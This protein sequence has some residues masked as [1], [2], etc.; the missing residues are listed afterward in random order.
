MLSTKKFT[1]V[2]ND[3]IKPQWS[4]ILRTLGKLKSKITDKMY[5]LKSNRF[6]AIEILWQN[7][8]TPP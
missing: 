6:T 4:K 8:Q 2:E 5:T 3:P 1:V 7:A